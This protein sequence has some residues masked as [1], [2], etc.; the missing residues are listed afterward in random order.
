MD[1]DEIRRANL[2]A[3]IAEA[4]NIDALAERSGVSAK[5]IS[6]ILNKWQGKADRKPR[7]VGTQLARRI[8]TAL[9][10]P[11]AWMDH[12][13][14]AAVKTPRA[15]HET[16]TNYHT[17]STGLEY[18]K[19]LQDAVRAI[20]DRAGVDLKTLITDSDEARQR[21][22]DAIAKR[23]ARSEPSA[24]RLLDLDA[25]YGGVTDTARIKK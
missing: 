23:P 4:G 20:A 2:Q 13:H 22:A 21:I 11:H 12:D 9:G 17:T 7:S 3:L 1:I 25:P 24:G 10:K 6:Q 14:T 15:A 5:Y 16:G 19:A 18:A 8:E